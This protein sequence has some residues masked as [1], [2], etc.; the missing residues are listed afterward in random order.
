MTPNNPC[1]LVLICSYPESQLMYEIHWE[2]SLVCILKVKHLQLTLSRASNRPSRT[3]QSTRS[4]G[5]TFALFA[6]YKSSKVDHSCSSVDDTMTL[7]LIGQR[8][9]V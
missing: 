9:Y 3:Q 6:L 5:Y 8:R 7:N 1:H 4:D 2:I